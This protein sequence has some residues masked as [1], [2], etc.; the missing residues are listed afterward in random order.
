MSEV[1]IFR[2]KGEIR[3]AN[4]QTSFQKE[5]RG[6]HPKDVLEKIYTEFGSR[7]RVK[8]NQIQIIQIEEITLD[9]IEDPVVKKLS[10]NV[11]S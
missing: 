10:G 1:K 3:K 6:L 7:H 2:V 8:R 11:T 4:Y 5:V 9:E